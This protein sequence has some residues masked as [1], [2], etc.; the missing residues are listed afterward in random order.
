M[1]LFMF[2]AE[3]EDIVTAAC[4][5]PAGSSIKC[6][7][8]CSHVGAILYALEDFNRKYFKTFVKPLTCTSQLSKWNVPRDSLTNPGPF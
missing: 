7:G 3:S 5:C 8:K 6:L 2:I 1:E 4:T